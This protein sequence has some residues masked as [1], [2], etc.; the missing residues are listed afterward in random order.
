MAVV[1]P[2]GRLVALFRP[3]LEA[4][5]IVADLVALQADAAGRDGG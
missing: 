2:L 4:G 3:P 1:D 5:A